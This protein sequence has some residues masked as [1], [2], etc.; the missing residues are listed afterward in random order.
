VAVSARERI[1]LL[2]QQQP[3]SERRPAMD[4]YIGVDVHS[5]SATFEVLS[6]TGKTLRRDVMETNGAALVGYLK[7][8]PGT[9]H[10]CIEEGEWSH[11]LYEIFLPHAKELVVYRG[12]R[13]HGSKS[14]AIDAHALAEKIRTGKVGSPVFK[15]TGCLTALREAARVNGMVTRDLVRVKNRLK[16]LYRSRGIR[17]AG[18]GVYDP[19]RRTAL[20][21]ELPIAMR[22]TAEFLGAE[23]DE[24]VDLKK[25]TEAAMIKESHR[26]RISRILETVPGLGPVR[27]AQVVPIVVTPY[28]FRTKRQFWSYAGFGIETHSSS[29]W[30]QE[31]GCWARRRVVQTRGLSFSHNHTLKGVFKGAATS[32][33]GITGPNPLR[34]VYERLLENGTKPNLAK[35]TIA[36]KIAAI[37]LA[38]WKRQERYA[39]EKVR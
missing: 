8:I 28:R 6:G 1:N 10:V 24:L 23:L 12:Q 20:V 36:R 21:Q 31:D 35:L 9:L 22:R 13:R 18:E 34:E 7:Q 16:S 4:R 2:G 29:D 17:C 19:R 26:H 37:T 33:L 25:R 15:E 32:A 39:P 5:A 38:M 30:V 14:D 11:W 27:V 3:L